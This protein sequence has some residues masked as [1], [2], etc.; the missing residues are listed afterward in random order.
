MSDDKV[1][2]FFNPKLI[3]AIC[4]KRG[5]GTIGEFDREAIRSLNSAYNQLMKD[6]RALRVEHEELI[7]ICE[8]YAENANFNNQELHHF[9]AVECRGNYGLQLSEFDKKYPQLNEKE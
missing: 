7:K 6:A 2:E 5:V 3:D 8:W 1:R 4:N 9:L